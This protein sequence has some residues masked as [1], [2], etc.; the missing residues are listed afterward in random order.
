MRDGPSCWL[1]FFSIFSFSLSLSL[2]P[3]PLVSPQYPSPPHP[4]MQFH[5]IKSSEGI[6]RHATSIRRA[7]SSP[8]KPHTL[9]VNKAQ[10][11]C[12]NVLQILSGLHKQSCFL[13][14]LARQSSFIN[15]VTERCAV[16]PHHL[17]RSHSVLPS[18]PKSI[19]IEFFF[20]ALS[21]PFSGQAPPAGW[22][23][24]TILTTQWS[25]V[26]LLV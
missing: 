14:F 23:E 3:Y 10:H 5:P 2:S 12:L 11:R 22:V 21:P 19:L 15:S 9:D 17:L 24:S 1:G 6:F 20:P 25:M 13:W 16:V 4:P 8:A 7:V 26:L 18:N